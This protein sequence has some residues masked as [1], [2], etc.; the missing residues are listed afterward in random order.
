MEQ[1]ILKSGETVYC[2]NF[3]ENIHFCILNVK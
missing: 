3:I 1:Y 2:V